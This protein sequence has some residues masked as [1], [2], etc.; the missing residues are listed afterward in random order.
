MQGETLVIYDK[1]EAYVEAL[2]DYLNK[3][4]ELGIV[5]VAFSNL[6]KLARY[7]EEGKSSYVIAGEGFD[8]ES[9]KG[10][11]SEDKIIS[12][13]N[14]KDIDNS[15]PWIYKYQSAQAITKELKS[16]MIKDEEELI[17]ENNLNIIFSTKSSLEREEYT[18]LLL[19]DL[20]NKGSVLYVD[21]EPFQG[22]SDDRY[23][24]DRGMSELIYYLK[25]GGEKV[26]WKFKSLIEREDI[27]GRILPV[28]SPL[29]LDELTKEDVK[30]LLNLFKGLSEYD[31]ILVNLG[32]LNLATFELIKAGSHIEIVVT[33]KNGDRESAENFISHL[34]KLGMADVERRVEII[35]FG[36]DTWI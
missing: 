12:L 16:I 30:T 17:S 36:T 18:D 5:T 2:S 22:K 4:M 32:I 15:E 25:Q 26:K 6:Y 1:E 19:S 29:D 8:K 24:E 14:A 3:N 13:V 10:K 21:M 27:S 31:F 9:I 33:R 35:E 20:K 28:H 11:I 34:K 23:R 7:L